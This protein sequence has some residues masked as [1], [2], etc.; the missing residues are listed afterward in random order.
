MTYYPSACV[1]PFKEPLAG[2]LSE[3]KATAFHYVDI[4]TE[5][6][7]APGVA[8]ALKQLGLKVSCVALDHHLPAGSSLESGDPGTSRKALEYLG[9]G[10]ERIAA[11]GARAAFVSPCRQQKNL[12][13]FSSALKQL[14]DLAASRQ[15]RICVKHAPGS[16]LPTAKSALAFVN[17]SQHTNLFLLLDSGRAIL[18]REKAWEII[19]AAGTK[20][21]YVQLNDN[22]GRSERH[23]PL[24][25]G[26]M[27]QADLT[28]ILEALQQS[29][30]V[31]TLGLELGHDRASIVCGLAKNRNLLLRLQ[32][33][34]EPKSMKEPEARRKP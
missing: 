20:L 34:V 31:G 15:I 25:D 23:W 28:R 11:V 26:R 21:G 5:S 4:E 12:K 19:A 8:E 29:G 14:A 16:G 3:L 18:A 10:L 1:W 2:V 22:D 9:K 27:T 7:D 30:Y 17:E 32:M 13:N 24:L 33:L 6:L